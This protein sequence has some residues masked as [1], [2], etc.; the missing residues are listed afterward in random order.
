M[1]P[2]PQSL[3]TLRRTQ[4]ACPRRRRSRGACMLVLPIHANALQDSCNCP[5]QVVSMRGASTIDPF[6]G[7][8]E[9]FSRLSA[10]L[11]QADQKKNGRGPHH[12]FF[13]AAAHVKIFRLRSPSTQQA[14]RGREMLG[15][16]AGCGFTPRTAT[17]GENVAKRLW[18][19]SRVR[20][21]KNS[22]RALRRAE[23]VAVRVA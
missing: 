7:C 10:R 19:S 4:Y 13:P 23:S 21:W 6:P 20:Y 9:A 16:P 18:Q 8:G 3:T 1:P 11:P 17:R 22:V 2:T 5:D 15:N 12:R 14:N